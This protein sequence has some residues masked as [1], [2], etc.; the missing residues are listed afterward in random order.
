MQTTAVSDGK[1]SLFA[2]ERTVP[3][4]RLGTVTNKRITDHRAM[5]KHA[6]IDKVRY[7]IT[8]APLPEGFDGFVTPTRH[9]FW[10]NPVDGKRWI[11]GTVGERY[12]LIQPDDVFGLFSGLGHPWEVMGII[13]DGR[14]MFGSIEWER[15]VTLD[16]N[17]ADEKVR[18][19]LTVRSSNDGSGS[20]VGGRSS[21][22]FTCFN[23]FTARFK[24]LAD[25]FSVRHTLSAA[26]K[27]AKIR[28]ELAK[29]DE[30]F[31]VQEVAIREMFEAPM[32][33]KEFWSIVESE[34]PR[35]EKVGDKDPAKAAVTKWENRMEMISQAWRTDANAG[36]HGTVY[37]GWQAMLEASQWGRNIQE[38]RGE[39]GH[40]NFWR[41]GAGFDAQT[42]GNRLHLFD[43]FYSQVPDRSLTLA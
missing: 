14:E 27:M 33:E 35:P 6:G 2:A 34:F 15:E 41:A 5:M 13:N 43:R 24:N 37:G 38:G 10:D 16:P 26:Q 28:L 29:T 30:F 42:E 7:G 18:S 9:T 31:N 32:V 1:R 19:W 4:Y 20:L 23:M 3:Y 39:R 36:I 21:M 12:T 11:L 25:K 17:G 22:R 40:E 8:D